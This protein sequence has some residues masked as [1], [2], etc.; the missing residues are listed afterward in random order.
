MVSLM[1]T[2]QGTFVLIFRETVTSVMETSCKQR[3]NVR[4]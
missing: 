2:F 3:T 1:D 4:C